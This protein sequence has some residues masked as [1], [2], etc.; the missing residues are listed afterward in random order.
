M[1][2]ITTTRNNKTTAFGK[3]GKLHVFGKNLYDSNN[4]IISIK[5][6]STHN[7]SSFPEYV[8]EDTFAWLDDEFNCEI[9]RLS[10]YSS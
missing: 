5:G 4:N 3:Y 1:N 7:L 10:M 2:T 6:V 9:K 8:N